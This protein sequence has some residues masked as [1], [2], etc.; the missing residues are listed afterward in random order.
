MTPHFI[1]HVR[2]NCPVPGGPDFYFGSLAAIFEE[3]RPGDIG[4]GL[5][6]LYTLRVAQGE[7]Y[8]GDHCTIKQSRLVRK[9]TKRGNDKNK[10]SGELTGN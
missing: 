1:Y 10:A 5:K 2:F 8:E 4:V 9:Q 7:V 6:R 3:F